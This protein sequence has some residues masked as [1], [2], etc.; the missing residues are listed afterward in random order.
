MHQ[1]DSTKPHFIRC[2][3]PNSKQRPV[4]YDE[5][6][7]LKQL[8]C[9]GVLEVAKISRVAYPTRMTHQEFSRR[10]GFLLSEATIS[11]DPLSISV[12]VLQKFNILFEMYQV[13][14]TKLYLRAGQIYVKDWCTSEFKLKC[15]KLVSAS[16]PAQAPNAQALNLAS[17]V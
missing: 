3:R 8:K 1:L 12:A 11:Q 17:V 14:Y 4:I 9:C 10:Y 2:I 6:L 7:V 15:R 16:S 5:D 13:G